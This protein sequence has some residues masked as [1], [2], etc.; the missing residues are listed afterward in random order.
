MRIY[1]KLTSHISYMLITILI[2]F[3]ISCLPAIR[4]EQGEKHMITDTGKIP[5]IDLNAPSEVETATFAMG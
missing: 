3:I 2:G 5:L 1:R 4:L